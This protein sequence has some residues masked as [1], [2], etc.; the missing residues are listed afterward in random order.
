MPLARIAHEGGVSYAEVGA[1]GYTLLAPGRGTPWPDGRREELGFVP[2]S[3]ARLLAPVSPRTLVGMAHNTG[4]ADR[5]LPPQ[6]FLK[7]VTT[8][9]GSGTPIP[10]PADAGL[11]EA[12]AELAVI[13]GHTARRLTIADA[14]S[15]VLGFTVANDVTSRDLQRSDPLWF[16]AK[17]HDGWTPLG[18]WLVTPA[19]L[20]QQGL[21]VDELEIQL[22]VDGVPGPPANTSVLARSIIECLV[23][24][25]GV[26]T[27]HPGDVV[28]TG[29]PGGGAPIRPGCQVTAAVLGIGDL[30]NPVVDACCAPAGEDEEPVA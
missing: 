28:L 8:I 4:P 12:E 18:P 2:A 5:G 15:H 19:E 10:V 7:P 9:T 3:C 25:T 27:L 21:D 1:G 6:A 16:A 23:Y 30:Q 13:I 14:L 24:V 26:L 22:S 17:G 11:V 29:A 20:D